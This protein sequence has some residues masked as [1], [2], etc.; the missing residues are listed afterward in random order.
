MRYCSLVRRFCHSVS[1][2]TSLGTSIGSESLPSLVM[3]RRRAVGVMG[4]LSSEALGAAALAAGGRSQPPSS[5]IRHRRVSDFMLETTRIG[6]LLF[7]MDLSAHPSVFR[8]QGA[9]N[10]KLPV[11][12]SARFF[13]NKIAGIGNQPR[14]VLGLVNQPA[15]EISFED[16]R[17]GNIALGTAQQIAVEH[18]Q[19]GPLAGLERACFVFP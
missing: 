16:F 1:E 4:F 3:R 12:G 14:L 5:S 11:I 9:G 15:V 6:R 18:N 8:P 17:G 10:W 19:I 13:W 2:S 7:P